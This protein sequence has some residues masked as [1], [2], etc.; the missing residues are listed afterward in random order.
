MPHK[1]FLKNVSAAVLLIAASVTTPVLADSSDIA[2]L[3]PPGD[4]VKP[5]K[6]NGG[7][8]G[9]GGTTLPP[10]DTATPRGWMHGDVPLAWSYNGGS[11]LGARDPSAAAGQRGVAMTFV[12][13]FS[14]G[15]LR[16]GNLGDGA[17]SLQHGEWTSREGAMIAPLADIRTHDVFSGTGVTLSSYSGVFNVLNL[18][19]SDNYDPA[20]ADALY[21]D[22]TLFAQQETTIID[23]AKSGAA[24]V[25]KSAGNN[26]GTAVGDAVTTLVAGRGRPRYQTVRDYLS[27]GLMDAAGDNP[28]TFSGVWVGALDGNS[29]VTYNPDGS[30]TVNTKVSIASY[31]TQAGTDSRVNAN[32]LMVGVDPTLNGGL[33]GTSFAAPIVSGYAAILASKFKTATPTQ[34]KNQLLATAR[35]D[36]INDYSLTVHGQGEASIYRA[37]APDSI[38]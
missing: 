18:S 32:Y 35:Q 1:S 16:S 34:V 31:S 7:G 38:Q 15:N 5:D 37:V 4:K 36:T 28:A 8:G 26:G 2:L 17:F 30:S 29:S 9:G 27:V 19:Y 22:G 11:Y 21:A 14:S 23:F 33:E 6:G 3:A 10:I 24:F 13:D 20:S 12:D 25:A